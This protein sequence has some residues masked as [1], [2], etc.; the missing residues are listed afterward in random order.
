MTHETSAIEPAH[1]TLDTITKSFRGHTAV[2][3]LSLSLAPGELLVLL[4]P[5][6]CG[7]STT[8]NLVAGFL[9]L[10]SGDIRVHGV[11]VVGVPVHR[12]HIGVVFQSYSLFPHMTVFDNTAFGLRRRKVPDA[13]LR[14]RVMHK[15]ELV[16]IAGLEHR[17]PDELSGGQRQ[18]VA[19]ARALVIEPR[20]LLLDEPLSNLDAKLR[21]EMR[22]E[23]RNLV[24]AEGVTTVFVT[25]D[26]EEALAIAD[27]VGVMSHGRLLQLAPP[28]EIYERPADLTVAGFVGR[29]N[30]LTGTVEERHAGEAVIRL[31][32][33]ASLRGTAV[34][35]MQRGDRVVTLVRPESISVGAPARNDGNRIAGRLVGETFL[36]Q[37]VEL[38]FEGPPSLIAIE[39]RPRPHTPGDELDLVWPVSETLVYLDP[40]GN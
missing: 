9:E 20:L 25:H 13:Q 12:R 31:D 27:R 32:T 38:T 4:G 8:L 2:D 35:D 7:K 33:G 36:G 21:V 3:N 40:D 19:L 16:G 24:S 39:G 23:I 30:R 34:D 28:R 37:H 1:L 6:G 17:F 10:D 29:S 18:R 14:E 15:L 5:S 26:Q 22:R 11:S